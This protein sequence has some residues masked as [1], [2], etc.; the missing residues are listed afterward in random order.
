MISENDVVIASALWLAARGALPR[1]AC[2]VVPV[3]GNRYADERR[4]RD[5]LAAAGIDCSSL[6]FGSDGPDVIAASGQEYWQVECKGAGSG[7]ASTM[8]NNFDRALAS[9]VSFFGTASELGSQC[10]G[11]VP[12]LG[13]ALPTTREYMAQLRKRVRRSLRQQL[14]LWILLYEPETR[15]IL[16]VPP[17][18][19]NPVWPGA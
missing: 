11:R 19:A 18:E 13:L 17:D 15:S 2:M 9:A 16:P 7:Q 6:R 5:A 4:L 3:E 1:A 10:G 8:R 12:L 14:G